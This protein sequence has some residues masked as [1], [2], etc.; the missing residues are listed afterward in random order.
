MIA[1]YSRV[2]TR[3]QVNGYSIDEQKE[4]MEAYC[5]AKGFTGFK[6]YCDPAFSGGN[7]NRPALQELLLDIQDKRINGVI[8]YKL[9]R[10]SRSQKDTLIMVNDYFLKNDCFFISICENFDT[11]SP[12]GRAMLGI[13]SVFAELEREQIKERM[14]VGREGRAKAGY[15]HGGANAPI[16]YDYKDGILYPNEDA[17]TVKKIFSDFVNGKSRNSIVT[18]LSRNGIE[19]KKGAYNPVNV[20]RLLKNSVYIGNITFNGQEYKGHHEPI[21]DTE[22]FYKAQDIFSKFVWKQTKPSKT[23]LGGLIF[24]GQCGTRYTVHT[25]HNYRYYCCYSR[26]KNRL[27][28][29]T[30]INCKNKNWRIDDLD[31]AVLN[32]IK[33]L[34]LKTAK[35][36]KKDYTK[37]IALI[38]KKISR[39][40]DLYAID[41]INLTDLSKKINALNEQKASLIDL[42]R[43]NRVDYSTVIETFTDIVENAT[44]AQLR[45]VVEV[46]IERIDL[47]NDN[48]TIHWKI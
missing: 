23:L 8:V 34:N 12:L 47:D 15:W 13:L 32:E 10:L 41:G 24:C 18:D 45:R 25:N 9:D 26:R 28:M 46:L 42:K 48:I 4:R 43:Q 20:R 2:S 3:E 39:L 40:T 11:D 35:T 6:H 19:H 14:T 44:T 37:E 38:D 29:I 5:K 16:G 36:K 30:D 21:I 17:N 22:T 27:S 33:K 31:N 1:L 7:M